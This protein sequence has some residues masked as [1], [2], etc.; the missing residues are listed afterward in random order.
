MTLEAPK[1]LKA[2]MRNTYNT[3]P[4][5]DT[6]FF[7]SCSSNT[8]TT[9]SSTDD[10]A[11]TSV[12]RGVQ[13]RRLLYGLCFFHAVAQ[14][15]RLYG[16]IGWNIAYE[17]NESDLSI[18]ARQA[19][20]FMSEVADSSSSSVVPF[21]ALRYTAGECNYGGRVTDDKDR[22]TLNC[23]LE[24]VYC[25]ASLHEGA[26]L[27]AS[28]NYCI[29]P[30]GNGTRD[31]YI[32]YID[33]LPLVA[34][35]EAFGL[36]EN[37]NIS[38]AQQDTQALFTKV[39]LTETGVSSGSS[40]GSNSDKDTVTKGI[41]MD[42]LAK[43]PAE[44]DIEYAQLKYPVQ[45]GESLNTVLCQ[46]LARFNSL[47]TVIRQTLNNICAAIDGFVV[48]SS[49]LELL[50]N[51]LFFGQIPAM[52]KKSSYPSL[53]PLGSYM[54]DLL[55]R[56]K[57]FDDWLKG[58][59]YPTVFWVCGFFFTQAFLTAALQNFARRYTVP[60]DNVVFDHIMLQQQQQLLSSSGS[61]DD[62]TSTIDTLQAPSD[63]VYI[64]GLYVEGARWHDAQHTLA[65]SIPKVLYSLAPTMWFKPVKREDL[66]IVPHYNCPVY[67]TSD[68]R[69]VLST[70]GHSTNFICFIRMPSPDT[71][72]SHWVL[73]GVCLLTTLDD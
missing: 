62:T 14:E 33:S 30:D 6:A 8:T 60:I 69:G 70:T 43:L 2:N 7:A 16:A 12:D 11:S 63:G 27:T 61:S 40:G 3:D 9:N 29:P 21:K 15:R 5:S 1:G 39:L 10:T 35:P 4:V 73:R 36:H 71:P 53:K 23:L 45:W 22:R 46:E 34:A 49:E 65:E 59:Q 72:E 50:G 67:K 56:I 31:S 17:F 19:A 13:F 24:R 66:H 52:W 28:G 47:L 20:M 55:Q 54:T 26:A 42:I 38:R 18:S 64:Q 68:R 51:D 25:E 48:M 41:A 37:A 58:S 57:F 32:S 44:F